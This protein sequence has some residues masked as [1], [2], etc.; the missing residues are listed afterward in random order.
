MHILLHD[1]ANYAFTKQLAGQ[2]AERGIRVTYAYNSRYDGPN[3]KADMVDVPGL[4]YLAV[5]AAA[6]GKPSESFANRLRMELA[7]GSALV[8]QLKDLDC[9]AVLSANTPSLV[10]NRLA[11]LLHRRHVPLFSWVQDLYGVAAHKLL[12]K[13]LPLL[14][15]LVGRYFI[16]L[17]KQSLRLSRQA[18]LI[19]ED[20]QPFAQAAGLPKD[21]MQVIENWAPVGDIPVLS[22]DNDWAR[23]QSLPDVFRFV[24]SGTLAMKHNPQLLVQLAKGL[25]A[26]AQRTS[27]PAA[28]LMVVSSSPGA[29]WLGE[30]VKEQQLRNVRLL[31]FQPAASF[32]SILG[33]ADILLAVLESDAAAFSVPSKVLSYLCAGKP[34]LAA[35]PGGNLAARIVRGAGAGRVVEPTDADEFAKAGVAMMNA[36]ETERETWGSAAREYA[37]RAFDLDRI[38][39]RFLD[40]LAAEVPAVRVALKSRPVLQ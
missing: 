4:S 30:Q 10:Q 12:R 19:T 3:S 21:R 13:R 36:S 26:H 17:D 9:D 25:L 20:F 5:G 31:N 1:Y 23:S 35:I 22:K 11:K 14:G 34:I 29:K 2:L 15:E 28:E 33:S 6:P 39:E 27:M 38:T 40:I 16:S 24:Y 37:E 7:Y 32:P 8:E 18:I